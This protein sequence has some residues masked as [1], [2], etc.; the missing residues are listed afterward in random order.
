MRL[1]TR[2]AAVAFA[3][4]FAA[5]GT[6]LAQKSGGTLRVYNTSNPPSASILEEVT[7]ATVMPFMAVF[8]NLVLL[9]QHRARN[10]LEGIVPELADS[11][12]WDASGTKLTFKLRQG[13]K[14]HDGKPF[15]AKDVRCTWQRLL[16]KED[17]F[18]KNPRRIWYANLEEVT[19][20]DDYQAT[21]HLT[22]PQPALI[23][24]LGSGMAPVY[25]CHVPAKDM[26]THPIGT[27]P[28][29]FV[30]FRANDSI[31]LARNSDYWRPGRPYL[32]AID[33]RIIPNRATRILAFIAG[34]FDLTFVGDVTVP[35]SKQLAAQAPQAQCR[36]VPTNVTTNLIV[37]R[38]I[39]PFNDPNIRR[40]MMLGLDRQGFINILSEGKASI[41]GAMMP[42]P[43][44]NW[45]MPA[46]MLGSLPGYAG[47]LGARQA[48]A[49][50][51]MERAG[52]GP[53]NRLKV[54][55]S[56]RDFQ[57]YK[58][59]AVIL[60][61]QL[62]K[63]HFEAELEIVES[64]VWFGRMVKKSYSVGLNLTGAAID[65]PD[66]MLKENYA[67]ES[68]NNFTKYCN[69]EVEKLLDAQSQEADSALRKKL[70][71]A[72]ER[73]LA[74]DVA[75]P[76]I[77][78]GVSNTCWQPYVKGHVQHANSIYNNWRFEDVWL[79]R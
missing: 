56:T 26:R 79:D 34:E 77:S 23:M 10:S 16:G 78:H 7:I 42:L 6:A 70:V 44:G 48:E 15:T 25:P 51:I 57:A 18:R 75:N 74:E 1:H 55:V 20:D 31:K 67:C 11:W 38:D 58:D 17:D 28:F 30:E 62:N 33:W 54:K 32:D 4:A 39:P 59:P 65:D 64:S 14:W 68:E 47:E 5:S 72:I 43:N 22:K 53:N 60:V 71:W 69:P 3:M 46:D 50:A 52:Y 2:G 8:N 9:D 35:I 45:G 29:K 37:N 61:D 13:V 19:V 27:G 36:L 49:R 76:I 73:K 41:S 63:I 24:L 40:A 21:F 12:A 66:S